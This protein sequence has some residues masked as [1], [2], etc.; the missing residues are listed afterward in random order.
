MFF[1]YYMFN[2]LCL[3]YNLVISISYML[4]VMV[5]L[6][7]PLLL[8]L[9]HLNSCQLHAFRFGI[10][11]FVI[12]DGG[13][14][15]WCWI[16]VFGFK[17]VGE[18]MFWRTCR[19]WKWQRKLRKDRYWKRREF[20]LNQNLKINFSQEVGQLAVSGR[21]IDPWLPVRLSMGQSSWRGSSGQLV[22]SR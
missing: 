16:E 9:T 12:N 1:I 18:W 22:A 20:C 3:L 8:S 14:L 21:L 17:I 2:W 10:F 15:S 19:L 7:F 13:W 4:Q 6:L 5:S 11:V